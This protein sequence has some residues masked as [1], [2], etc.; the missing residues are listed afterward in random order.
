MAAPGIGMAAGPPQSDVYVRRLLF[1]RNLVRG[2]RASHS[3]HPDQGVAGQDH[4]QDMVRRFIARTGPAV[5]QDRW[6]ESTGI[7]PFALA[8]C[9]AALVSGAGL[10][11]SP[12]SGWALELGDFWNS[13]VERWT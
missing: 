5:E 2:C 1:S 13:N 6:E 3:R 10:L 8:L 12:S 9:I 7:N 11:R 4:C